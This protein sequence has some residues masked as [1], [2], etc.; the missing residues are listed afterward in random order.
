MSPKNIWY[1][2]AI[3][4]AEWGYSLAIKLFPFILPPLKEVSHMYHVLADLLE[5]NVIVSDSP[6]ALA[7][8]VI[9]KLKDTDSYYK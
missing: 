3:I 9:A 4:L 2:D 7:K 6:E 1:G 8:D 5:P